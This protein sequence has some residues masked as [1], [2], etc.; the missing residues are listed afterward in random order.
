MQLVD[1]QTFKT[2]KCDQ[3]HSQKFGPYYF[4]CPN[5]HSKEDKRRNPFLNNQGELLYNEAYI[6]DF[7]S[8]TMCSNFV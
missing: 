5:Y 7:Y 2:R 8:V 1:I 6:E 4:N 3:N